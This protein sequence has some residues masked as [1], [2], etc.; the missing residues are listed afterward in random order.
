M[1]PK[2]LETEK[3]RT[4]DADKEAKNEEYEKL[5][6]FLRYR[7]LAAMPPLNGVI[8]L[9]KPVT[10]DTENASKNPKFTLKGLSS[11]L[12]IMLPKKYSNINKTKSTARNPVLTNFN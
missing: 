7:A 2:K 11:S 1:I 5:C 9:Q 12:V 4:Y 6:F 10:T 3:I 8:R